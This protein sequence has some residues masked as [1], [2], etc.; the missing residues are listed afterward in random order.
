MAK[1]I[2]SFPTPRTPSEMGAASSIHQHG[3]ISYDGKIGAVAGLPVFTGASGVLETKSIADTRTALSV[4]T[5]LLTTTVIYVANTGSDLSG[6]GSSANPYATPT[7]A[8]STIPKNLN[9]YSATINLGAG[10]YTDDVVISGFYGGGRIVF[11]GDTVLSSTR[12]VKSLRV[13][14]CAVRVDVLGINAS[15]ESDPA[16]FIVSSCTYVYMKNL[17]AVV[18]STKHGIYVNATSQCTLQACEVSNHNSAVV[19]ANMSN[20][21]VYGW[22]AGSGNSAGLVASAATI[23][24]GVGL[25]SGTW[26]ESTDSGGQ[27]L[28][29]SLAANTTINVATTGSDVTGDGSSSAPYA[30]LQK[31]TDVAAKNLNGY[32]LTFNVAAGTYVGATFKGYY[33]GTVVIAFNGTTT[34]NGQLKFIGNSAYISSTGNITI[35]TS[36][37]SEGAIDVDS[38][39]V[40]FAQTVTLTNSNSTGRGVRALSG[41]RVILNIVNFTAPEAI[42]SN[43]LSIVSITSA[44]GTTTVG[45]GAYGADIKVETNSL[46]A[47]TKVS[48]TGG[49]TVFTGAG[50]NL[51]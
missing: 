13:E 26:A 12:T 31:A 49:G 32:T 44:T 24:K 18:T 22:N 7:K 6:D 4:S 21:A 20:V 5:A 3:S 1:L 39:I 10:T 38:S 48:K 17:R 30:T 47:T 16:S 50:V 34:I 40:R 36:I 9:G 27:I 33:G 23:F 29:T 28:P 8:I 46:T 43:S 37:A 11:Q 45:Y 2:N 19:S 41:S 35:S 42:V 14:N 15:G 25:P 51:T